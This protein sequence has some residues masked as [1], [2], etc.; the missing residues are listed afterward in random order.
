MPGQTDPNDIMNPALWL[1][2][3]EQLPIPQTFMGSR[4]L[5]SRPVESHQFFYDVLVAEAPMAQFVARGAPAP[6]MDREIIQRALAEVGYIKA[7]AAFTENDV[8]NVRYPFVGAEPEAV[9]RAGIMETAARSR[10]T[11]GFNVAAAAVRTR[12]EWAQMNALAGSVVVTPSLTNNVQFDITF[13]VLTETASPLWSSVSTADPALDIQ[14]WFA[15]L[16]WTPRYAIASRKTINN[17]SRNAKLLTQAFV[18]FTGVA[19]TL[20]SASQVSDLLRTRWGIELIEYE[21]RYTTR[22]DN[23][24]VATITTNRILDED[25]VIFLPAEEIGF[26]ADAPAAQNG[27]RTGE[28]TWVDQSGVTL[29]NDPWRHEAGIG[30]YSFPVLEYPERVLVA[31][32][33]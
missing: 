11:R 13:P 29:P 33:G 22:A 19:P 17:L 20:V 9:Q 5:P 18:P 16:Y 25:I 32:V 1:G 10:M 14:T 12:L 26:T 28:F 23:G 21:S 7:K 27:F 4:F 31:T 2:V 3:L 24:A 6:R 8:S 15:D 30:R